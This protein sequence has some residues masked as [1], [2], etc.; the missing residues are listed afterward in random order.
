MT[1]NFPMFFAGLF[2]GAAVTLA[3]SPRVRQEAHSALNCAKRDAKG[4]IDEV[5]QGAMN[6][7]AVQKNAIV[8]SVEAAKATYRATVKSAGFET[9]PME[10][11]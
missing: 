8:N 3:M 5:R 2:A 7:A 9:A 4:A 1:K 6:H 11:H 10:S